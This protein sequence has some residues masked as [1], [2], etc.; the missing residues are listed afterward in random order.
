MLPLV[1]ST[2]V[3]PGLSAPDCSASSIIRSA[4]RSFTDPPGLRYST[5]ARTVGRDALGDLVQPHQRGVADEVQDDR[6]ISTRSTYAVKRISQ[7]SI[8]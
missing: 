1:G 3:P 4:I 8:Q 7:F 6:L 2:I 5:L